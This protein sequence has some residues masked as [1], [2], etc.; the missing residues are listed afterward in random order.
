MPPAGFKPI[1][2][3]SHR[4]QTVTL[5]RS[6]T[7]TSVVWHTRNS[8]SGNFSENGGSKSLEK[9]LHLNKTTRRHISIGCTLRVLSVKFL[10]ST[11]SYLNQ[12]IIFLLYF[13]HCFP[14]TCVTHDLLK[15]TQWKY[16]LD[17]TSTSRPRIYE[18]EKFLCINAYSNSLI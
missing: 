4:L 17:K 15:S 6:A 13:G 5:D 2:S 16:R 11:L 14:D 8:I 12:I 7:G 9:L 18:C 1:I 10:I 3:A